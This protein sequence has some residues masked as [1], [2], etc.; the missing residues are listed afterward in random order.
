MQRLLDEFSG[1]RLQLKIVSKMF[2][3]MELVTALREGKADVGDIPIPWYAGTYPIWNWSDIPG[4][5]TSEEEQNRV[6]QLVLFENPKLKGLLD[7]IYRETAGITYLGANDGGG[8]LIL[9]SNK[10]IAKLDD[11][12]GLKVRVAGL[13]HAMSAKAMGL[14]SVTMPGSEVVPSLQSGLLDAAVTLPDY[15]ISPLGLHKVTKYFTTLPFGSL[16][17]LVTGMNAKKY[18]SLPPDLQQALR[19]VA[20]A[21]DYMVNLSSHDSYLASFDFLKQAGLEYVPFA[22]WDKAV[23]MTKSVEDE[24]LKI[25]GP[26]GPE[27]LPLVK[28]A[29]ADIRAFNPNPK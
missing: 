16:W 29:L 8:Q 20:T 6:E 3:S 15:A 19:Q 18:D 7:K 21:M 2:P 24:W 22:D 27:V 17:P 26:H 11:L 1:G 13:I 25:A 23:E 28:S 12:K 10:K 14:A 9:F 5:L 4:L